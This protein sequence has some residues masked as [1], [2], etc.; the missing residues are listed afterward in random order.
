MESLWDGVESDR[1]MAP[2]IRQLLWDLN[3]RLAAVEERLTALEIHRQLDMVESLEPE[4]NRF[5]Y[6]TSDFLSL[7]PDHK[8]ELSLS[9]N[10]HRNFYQTVEEYVKI[11]DVHDAEWVNAVEMTAAIAEDELWVLEWYP[12]TPV[13]SYRI[14]GV[15]FYSIMSVLQDQKDRA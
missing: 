12:D 7:L 15:S 4:D 9:H 8:A 13:G 1:S 10:P 6:T 5:P 11:S 3:T 2:Q 14:L